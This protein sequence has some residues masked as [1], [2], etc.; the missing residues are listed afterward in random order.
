MAKPKPKP[1]SPVPPF[2]FGTTVPVGVKS[3]DSPPMRVTLTDGTKLEVQ[4]M[5][6]DIMRSADRYNEKGEPVYAVRTGQLIKSIVPPRLKLK[7]KMP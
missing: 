4:T 7:K 2:D 3:F 1:F 6:V 5:I